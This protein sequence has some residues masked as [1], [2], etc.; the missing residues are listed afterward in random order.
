MFESR[1]FKRGRV[2]NEGYTSDYFEQRLTTII[3]ESD[4]KIRLIKL[5][6]E[7]DWA[8]KL[9]PDDEPNIDMDNI[10]PYSYAVDNELMACIDD[11][12]KEGYTIDDIL[13]IDFRAKE[14]I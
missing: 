5:L 6:K 8:K 9:T 3:D 10:Y 1:K 12:K 4:L 7:Y 11:M 2:V 13:Q 14:F